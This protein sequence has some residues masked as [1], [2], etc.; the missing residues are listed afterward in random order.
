[1]MK[2]FKSGLDKLLEI[3]CIADFIVMVCLTL[4]QVVMR[5]VFRS[6]SSVSEVLARYCFV[7]LILLSATY[8]F[9]QRDH[10][11]ISFLK[12]K[13]TGKV[14]QA[15]DVLTECVIIVFSASILVYGGAV[16]TNMNMLQY[17]SI[18]KVPTG[19]I[20]SVIPVCGVLIIFYSI[21][22]LSV[23]LK[24]GERG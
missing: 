19:M 3:L 9:G 7:W 6:P 18:L 21:Y 11:C 20:Y 12:D 17:D 2:N 4:F 10:I 15:M 13:M 8:V 1:M 14:R 23:C 16:I 22:N 5:Y 24:K